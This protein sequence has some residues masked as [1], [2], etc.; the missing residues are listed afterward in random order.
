[1]MNNR[2]AIAALALT[3]AIGMLSTGCSSKSHPPAA[4]ATSTT[5]TPDLTTT[6]AD[7]TTSDIADTSSAA[8]VPSSI[9]ASSSTTTTIVTTTFTTPAAVPPPAPAA[10][11]GGLAVDCTILKPIASSAISQLIPLQT[12]PP[13]QAQ[14]ARSAYVS[15]LRSSQGSLTSPQGRADLGGLINSVQTATTVADGQKVLGS[16][17]KIR[18]D[19]P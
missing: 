3:A 14:A 18:A 12:L 10:A 19:C 9:P 8:V 1:M 16:L 15:K 5:T 2:K 17:S 7:T 11:P 13:A 6:A 4:S